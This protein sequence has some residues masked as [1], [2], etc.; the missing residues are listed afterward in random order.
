MKTDKDQSIK[1]SKMLHDELKEEN[2]RT[3]VPFKYLLEKAWEMYKKSKG[4]T[5]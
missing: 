5:K 4:A 3:K 2:D 1:I